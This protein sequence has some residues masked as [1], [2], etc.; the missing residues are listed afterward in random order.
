MICGEVVGPMFS[1]LVMLVIMLLWLLL[2][3]GAVF[4]VLYWGGC[5]PNRRPVVGK[6]ALVASV[7]AAAVSGFCWL[8]PA[9]ASRVSIYSEVH[10]AALGAFSALLCLVCGILGEP[11][12][13]PLISLGVQILVLAGPW[14]VV[15]AWG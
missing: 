11:R 6:A 8:L 10:G 4:F 15:M 1:V 9:Y 7:V 3:L 2:W 12:K 13:L 5:E 14:V